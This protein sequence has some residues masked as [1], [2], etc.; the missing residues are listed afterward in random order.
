VLGRAA[1]GAG[2]DLDRR[3]VVLLGA[4]LQGR[5]VEDDV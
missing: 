5:F 3:I 4:E 2:V 1:D